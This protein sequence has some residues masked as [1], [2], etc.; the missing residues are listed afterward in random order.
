MLFVAAAFA[1]SWMWLRRHPAFG[2]GPRALSHLLAHDDGRWDIADLLERYE[3]ARLDD[4]SVVT[5]RLLVLHFRLADGRRRHRCILGD[6]AEPEALRRLHAFLRAPT[7]C[8]A[9]RDAP[10]P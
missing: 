2:Y 7:T 10:P 8:D 5:A 3:D 6:E 4:D 9:S 1:G